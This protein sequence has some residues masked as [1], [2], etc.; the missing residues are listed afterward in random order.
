MNHNCTKQDEFALSMNTPFSPSDDLDRLLLSE[1]HP[2]CIDR[3]AAQ[4]PAILAAR[5]R[6]ITWDAIA[7]VLDMKRCTLINAVKTL[8][9]RSEHLSRPSDKPVT[10]AKLTASIHEPLPKPVIASG[11]AATSLSSPDI[12]NCSS[13][14]GSGVRPVGRA[15][16][17]QFNL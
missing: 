13:D 2:R 16:I 1:Q 14:T 10:P 6:K 5:Q 8:N 11:Q 17:E 12:S 15:R 7:N 4:L 3:V 9:S